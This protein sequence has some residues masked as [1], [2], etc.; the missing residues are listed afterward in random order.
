MKLLPILIAVAAL[1]A[2]IACAV[3][4]PSH[5]AIPPTLASR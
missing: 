3:A 5:A 4:A 1:G 2:A